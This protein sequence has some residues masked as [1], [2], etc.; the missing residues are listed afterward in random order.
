M[1][2]SGQEIELAVEKAAAGGRMIARHDGQVV[3]VAATLPGERVRARVER[4]DKR[5]AFASTIAVLEPSADRRTGF[6]DDRCGG[7]VFSHIAYPRQ[8]SLKSEIVRDAFL[9]IGRIPLADAV[10]VE[11]SP[12]VGYRMRARFHVDR[13]RAGFYREATHQWCD[14]APTGQVRA[15]SLRIVQA[16]A[17]GIAAAGAQA[18][19]VEL[20]E[21][22]AGTERAIAVEVDRIPEA[23]DLGGPSLRDA[24]AVSTLRGAILRDPSGRSASYGAPMVRDT[25]ASLTNGRA[26]DGDLARHPDA[27]FQANRFLLPPLVAAVL[28]AVPSSEPVVD[29]YAGV[30]LFS[31]ALAATGVRGVIAVEGDPVSGAD[32]RQNAAAFDGAL[33]TRLAAVE[34]ALPSLPRDATAIVDPPRTGM[35][36]EAMAALL[37]RK[38]SRVVYVSCDPATM[39]RDARKLLDA[40]YT[41]ASL[42]GFDFFP[43][44]P[45]VESLGVFNRA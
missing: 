13:G 8:T 12:E 15:D 21:N 35:S 27:F 41:L 32:L 3:L 31:V 6:E 23:F 36:P 19:S 7:C 40:G 20:I 5:L 18:L 38:P 39:A 25:L 24:D 43:N 9:R 2:K 16:A 42:R 37:G 33:T 1:L 34:E 29:L 26:G 10:P 30:G 14:P 17:D 28:D 44:T 45:H 22:L 11:G 4:A